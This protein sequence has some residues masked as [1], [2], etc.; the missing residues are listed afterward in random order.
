MFA[1]N[2]KGFLG[3]AAVI[4]AGS[5]IVPLLG[6]SMSGAATAKVRTPHTVTLDHT[7]TVYSS[8]VMYSPPSS[9]NPN[10]QGSFAT[11]TEGFLYETLFLYNP[12]K[13]TYIPWLARGGH[14]VNSTT[15]HLTLRAGV[16]W[17][18]GQPLTTADVVFTIE[19]SYNDPGI[20]YS[21]LGSEISSVSASGQTV[22]VVFKHPAAEDW[23]AFLYQDPILP[24]HI[25]GSWTTTQLNTDPNTTPVG[26]GPMTLDTAYTN[27]S[28]VCYDT[29]PNW[30]ATSALGL[31]FKFS[32][33]CD[34]VNSSNNVELTDFLTG[35]IDLSNNFLPGIASIIHS[36][37]PGASTY[38]SL[39]TYYGQ[40][41]YMLSANTVWLE[42]NLTKA[43][44]DNLY[45]REAVAEAV[46]ESQI[47][48]VDY[49]NLVKAANP[50]GLMPSQASYV[51][52]AAVKQFGFS[53]NIKQAKADLAKSNY[54]GQTVTI[55]CPDGWTDWMA[56]INLIVNDLKVVG[57]KAEA[58]FPSY[59]TRQ[60]DLEDGSYDFAIDNN[61]TIAADPYPYFYRM[62]RLPV[63]TVQSAQDN[64]E[65]SDAKTLPG[66]AGV[67]WKLV[68]ELNATATTDT[69]A[70]TAI[71]DQLETIEL[72]NLPEIP[73]WYNGAWAQYSSAN[74]KNWPHAISATDQYTPVMWGGWLGNMTT[75]LALAQLAHS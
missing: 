6:V 75:V 49:S 46:N 36:A 16:T 41:P 10:M 20:Y 40:A 35:E 63:L 73:V 65:R 56:A 9:W 52:T 11:G 5:L 64:W 27:A 12:I 23:Q 55:E 62:F 17:S 30:W 29:N 14:W 4:L 71:F 66:V 31:S 47:V 51:D 13:N 44:M 54:S 32:H 22:T 38:G 15:Y 69:T 2:K 70:R 1:R 48:S 68:Q 60:T 26:S 28:E 7:N 61:A 50:T 43:P 8:G 24:D 21:T 59:A 19:L 39:S 53:Y 33:W 58:Y 42:P 45:F 74:W 18:D 25:M 67:A 72:K 3:V 37:T 34:T 57:I